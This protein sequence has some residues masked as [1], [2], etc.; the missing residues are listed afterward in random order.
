MS[1]GE[2]DSN[3][4]LPCPLAVKIGVDNLSMKKISIG[5]NEY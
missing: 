5:V 3:E 4:A 2:G 1:V